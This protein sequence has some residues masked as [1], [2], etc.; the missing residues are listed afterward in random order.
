MRSVKLAVAFD[1]NEVY[2]SLMKPERLSQKKRHANQ[3]P[4]GSEMKNG[5]NALTPAIQG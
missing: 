2:S 1:K 4:T 5:D 3:K